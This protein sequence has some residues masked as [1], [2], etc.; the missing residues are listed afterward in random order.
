MEFKTLDPKWFIFL[1][2]DTISWRVKKFGHSNTDSKILYLWTPGSVFF[3]TTKLTWKDCFMFIFLQ[4]HAVKIPSLNREH[5][6]THFNQ[7]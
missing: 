4:K 5:S 7:G 1:F 2:N 3:P 6:K